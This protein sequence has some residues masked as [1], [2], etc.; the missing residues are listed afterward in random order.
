MGVSGTTPYKEQALSL[1]AGFRLPHPERQGW[2]RAHTLGAV[3]FITAFLHLY[4][5]LLHCRGTAGF[6]AAFLT[7]LFK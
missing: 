7:Y 6:L 1:S 2:R 3:S 4:P 5:H